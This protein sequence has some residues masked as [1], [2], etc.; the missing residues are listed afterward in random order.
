MKQLPLSFLQTIKQDSFPDTVLKI[1][2]DNPQALTET[3]HKV[4]T[5]AH[6]AFKVG[7]ISLEQFEELAKRAIDVGLH[8]LRSDTCLRIALAQKRADKFELLIP[9]FWVH[10]ESCGMRPVEDREKV[11]DRIKAEDMKASQY[12]SLSD[13]PKEIKQNYGPFQKPKWRYGVRKF[14]VFYFDPD[15][16][17][18]YDFVLATLQEHGRVFKRHPHLDTKK[19]VDM[20]K[21]AEAEKTKAVEEAPAAK[22]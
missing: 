19:L 3:E 14:L 20:L 1:I 7:Q 18:D 12:G 16:D 5:M 2:L 11:K 17:E 22:V 13:Y 15:R 8:L 21:L 10:D 6:K 9:P 4:L